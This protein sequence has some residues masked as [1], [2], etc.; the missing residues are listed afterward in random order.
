[1]IVEN[2]NLLPVVTISFPTAGQTVSGVIKITGTAM[3]QDGVVEKVEIR[4]DNGDWIVLD[5]DATGSWQYEWDTTEVEDG[6]HTIY[7]RA[8]DGVEFSEVIEVN[9]VV[10]NPMKVEVKRERFVTDYTI[11]IA[12]VMIICLLV[13]AIYWLKRRAHRG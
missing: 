3:D 11:V 4:I 7:V 5:L 2:V 9:V 6:E 8:F 12:L 13:T 10:D 1:V